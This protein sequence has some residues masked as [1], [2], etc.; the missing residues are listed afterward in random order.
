MSYA[1]PAARALMDN[2]PQMSA[3]EI[4]LKAMKLAAEMCVYTNQNFTIE[5]IEML[6]DSRVSIDEEEATRSKTTTPPPSKPQ[7]KKPDVEEDSD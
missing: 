1:L 5:K 4:A 6:P 7:D 3:E 2:C